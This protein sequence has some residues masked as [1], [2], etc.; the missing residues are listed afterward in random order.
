MV[1]EG[2]MMEEVKEGSDQ[3][4]MLAEDTVDGQREPLSQVKKQEP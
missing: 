1:E 4:E 2:E 3:L